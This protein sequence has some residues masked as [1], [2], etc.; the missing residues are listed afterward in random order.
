[1]S[2]SFLAAGMWLASREREALPPYYPKPASLITSHKLD[3]PIKSLFTIW[4]P[5]ANHYENE[6]NNTI[7][8]LFNCKYILPAQKLQYID[9]L[10]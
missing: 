7:K 3:L 4:S 10:R 2:E 6:S 5:N 9:M 8:T 1:M